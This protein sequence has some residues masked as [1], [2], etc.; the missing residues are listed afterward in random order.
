M[1][2][3]DLPQVIPV[4]PLDGVL[5]LPDGT[6]PLNVFEPRYL[7]MIDDAMAGD[8]TIGI[9]QSRSG[10][11]RQVPRLMEVGCVGR[12]TSFTETPDGRYLITLT[13]VC[14]FTLR[15][16]LD[17][18]T[19][20]RQ[21]RA[22]YAAWLD[23]LQ[24]ADE[25]DTTARDALFEALKSYLDHRGLAMDW[26]AVRAA[27]VN[28]LVSSLCM[29]LPFDSTEKQALLEAPS[30][31]DRHAALITLLRFDAAGG[32]PGEASGLQ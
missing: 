24:A 15:A 28:A 25:P 11:D 30:P 16:E 18:P 22:D 20:Y 7:N 26:D 17:L 4:F 6:L 19:P 13:G 2:A 10:G 31:T 21:V 12:I 8:R 9:I 14:R 27:P 5:L 1:R 29:A 3:S 23:D 32:Q